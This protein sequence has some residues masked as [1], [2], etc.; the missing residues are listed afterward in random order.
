MR[1]DLR[2]LARLAV[3]WVVD[4]TDC[5][6]VLVGGPGCV[7]KSTFAAELQEQFGSHPVRTAT[8]LD[9]DCY[10]LERAYRESPKSVITGYNP[11]AYELNI[12][13]RDIQSLLRG[14]SVLVRPYDKA[15]STR[16][17]ERQVDPARLLIVEGAMALTTALLRFPAVRAFLDAET[18]VLYENRVARERSLGF[19]ESRIQRKFALLDRDYDRFIVP[20]RAA[21]HLLVRVGR[22]YEFAALEMRAAVDAGVELVAGE[23][24][25]AGARSEQR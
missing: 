25:T 20:Q 10:L 16:G 21:A 8:V 23:V 7:G 5:R 11:A 22:G 24:M 19:E 2:R 12:A 3:E 9:L 1:P 18:D 17:P 4:D 14:K 13:T 15:T 6:V